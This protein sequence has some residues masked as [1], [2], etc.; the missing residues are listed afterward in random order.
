[1]NTRTQRGLAAVLG[2]VALALL[3]VVLTVSSDDAAANGA[4]YLKAL[5]ITGVPSFLRT[6]LAGI[7]FTIVLTAILTAVVTTRFV[8]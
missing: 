2:T 4:S 5:G 6:A 8:Q 3:G 1:M 7:V